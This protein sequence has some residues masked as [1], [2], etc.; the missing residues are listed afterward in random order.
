MQFQDSSYTSAMRLPPIAHRSALITGCST[1]I[2][3]ATAHRL[4]EKDWRVI[5]SA[6]KSAD[7]EKLA[8]DGFAAIQLDVADA[9]SVR[10]AVRETMRL[11]DGKLG[12][13]VNNAGFGQAGALEDISRTALRYQFE[14]NVFGLQ[15]LTNQLL[16]DMIKSGSGRIVHVSSVLGKLV[17][18]MYGA[19]CASKHAVEA[20]ADA[21]RVEL[22]ETGVGVILVE[23]GPITTEFRRNAARMVREKVSGAA[24]DYSGYY[25]EEVEGRI[26]LAKAESLISKPPEAVASVIERALTS[27][28]PQT[29]YT[30]TLPAHIGP[31]LRKI[32]P[33]ALYDRLVAKRVLSRG[34]RGQ[35]AN[36]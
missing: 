12:A 6:R 32:I 16:P 18:P 14:V 21:Q 25:D 13:L 35:Q 2:G 28:R 9:N 36:R 31:G 24:T 10:E 30:V 23:P 33:D 4:R 20:L 34:D 1:G 27:N 17:L 5:A 26:K 29:R 22:R 15:D 11:V 3:L 7:V 19:Y 8:R